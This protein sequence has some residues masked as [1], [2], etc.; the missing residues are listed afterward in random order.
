MA[1]AAHSRKGLRRPTDPNDIRKQVDLGRVEFDFH[2]VRY[3]RPPSE[4]ESTDLV[5]DYGG[6]IRLLDEDFKHETKIGRFRFRAFDVTLE[7]GGDNE[8][9]FDLVDGLDPVSLESSEVFSAITDHGDS[10]DAFDGGFSKV[11]YLARLNVDPEYRGNG[12]ARHFLWQVLQHFCGPGVGVFLIPSPLRDDGDLFRLA[13][14]S[15][16]ERREF[17]ARKERLIRLYET[18]GFRRLENSNVWGISLDEP[19]P[20]PTGPTG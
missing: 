19:F 11:I 20:A 8:E 9:A 17:E 15:A 13:E 3:A 2:F 12:I 5:T 14:L 1:K 16:E 4:D 10:L 6:E 7:P 18:A